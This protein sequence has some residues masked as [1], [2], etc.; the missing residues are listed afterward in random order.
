MPSIY[1]AI[2]LNKNELRQ[3]VVQNL[4][5][6]SPPTGP[7]KGQ[8]WFDSTNNILKW[9]DGGTW[10]SAM[11]GAGAVPADT[12]TTQAVGD[13]AAAGSS[14]LYSRGDHKHAMPAFGAIQQELNFGTAKVDGTA[15]TIARA[16]HQHGNPT[17]DVAAHSSFRITDLSVPVSPVNFGGQRLTNVADPTGA[18]DVATK[19]YTDNLAQGLDAKASVR[20]VETTS[21][22]GGGVPSGGVTIDSIAVVNG[23]RVLL[24]GQST[25]ANNGI[26]VVGTP[27]TRPTDF[28][29]WSEV[30][31]AYVWVEVGTLRADTGW[32]CTADAGGTIGSTAQT[33]VQ[34]AAAGAAIAGNGLTKTGNTFDFVTGD[35]SLTVS[36]DSV[37]VN[38]GVIATVASLASYTPTARTLTA[39]SGLT[40]GGTLASNRTFDVGA[41]TGINVAA[42][43]IAVDTT[44]IATRAYVDASVPVGMVKKYAA[45][46]T[47]TASP[48]T[49]THNLNTRDISLTVYNGA[50]PYTAVEVDWDATTTS[51]AVVRYAPNLGAGYR[52]VVMG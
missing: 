33:W 26:W 16:D 7:V 30:P 50:T 13:V 48:E 12:V 28:D 40:G 38:T 46:L 22:F 35:T 32:V 6:G 41:G 20:V 27:W 43:S 29:T 14:T 18:T 31:S 15:V 49:V 51:T 11:G 5:V 52:V 25:A 10:V 42:D 45:A 19:Q 21:V 23:D 8:L 4:A 9:Y 24:T 34:F 3:A 44:V 39:G 2:D 36:A 17:H 1:G 47:G 37:I